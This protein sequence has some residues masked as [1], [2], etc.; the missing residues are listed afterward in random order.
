MDKTDRSGTFPFSDCREV[1]P[2]LRVCNVTLETMCVDED[3][4]DENQLAGGTGVPAYLPT[5]MTTPPV[6]AS[7]APIAFRITAL[8]L[9]TVIDDDILLELDD[10]DLCVEQMP[11]T[12][13][14][15][16]ISAMGIAEVLCVG[17]RIGGSNPSRRSRS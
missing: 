3:R 6:G 17:L 16:P 1:E 2:V 11:G 14:L 7:G 5:E 15:A 13:C 12:V 4:L 10:V 8:C 9:A